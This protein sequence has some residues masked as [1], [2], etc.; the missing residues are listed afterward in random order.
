MKLNLLIFAMD[1]LTFLAYPFLFLYSKIRQ[2]SRSKADIAL[3]V[4]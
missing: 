1:L 3:K 4:I 2:I